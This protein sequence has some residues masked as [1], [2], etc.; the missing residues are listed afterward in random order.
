LL[1]PEEIK[2]LDDY[3]TDIV[4]TII[5]KKAARAQKIAKTPFIGA[6]V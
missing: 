5:D 2:E 6:W 3:R 4:N 1:S